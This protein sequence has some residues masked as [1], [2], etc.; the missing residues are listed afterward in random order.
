M[1]VVYASL[2]LAAIAKAAIRVSTRRLPLLRSV[3]TTR[4]TQD[5]RASERARGSEPYGTSTHEED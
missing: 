3:L 5:D 2:E 4:G 1:D